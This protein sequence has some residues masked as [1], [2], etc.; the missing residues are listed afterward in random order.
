M[1]LLFGMVWEIP[2]IHSDC[3]CSSGH[4]LEVAMAASKCP[5]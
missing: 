5:D 1:L 3:L 4:D 2:Q